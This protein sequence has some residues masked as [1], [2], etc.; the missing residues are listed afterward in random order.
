MEGAAIM[1]QVQNR[2]WRKHHRALQGF[3]TQLPPLFK[4]LFGIRNEEHLKTIVTILI[5]K[6]SWAMQ[7]SLENTRTLQQLALG[8]LCK[9]NFYVILREFQYIVYVVWNFS[10]IYSAKPPSVNH[11]S[12][13]QHFIFMCFSPDQMINKDTNISG[14]MPSF[15]W[16]TN[17]MKHHWNTI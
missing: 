15:A 16:K 11:F 12:L 6:P 10:K 14:R 8:S 9:L 7:F 17:K 13:S 5:F 3:I 1:L 2:A 4:Q